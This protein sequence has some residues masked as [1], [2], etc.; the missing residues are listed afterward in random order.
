MKTIYENGVV[1]IQADQTA[2]AFLVEDGR[3][4]K[5]GS[6]REARQWEADRR[7]DLKGR[8]VCPGFND[9]HMHLLNYGQSLSMAPLH[10]HTGSL[11]ALLNCLKTHM[12]EHPVSPGQW[13]T[14]RGWNQDFFTDV[15]RFPNRFDLDQVSTTVPV[16]ISRACGHAIVANS[17]ALELAGITESTP[18]I[19]GGEIVFE[20][21][22]PNGV[23]LDNAASLIFDILPAPNLEQIKDM[24]RLGCRA[25]NTYGVTSCQSDDYCVFSN[26]PWETVNQAFRELEQNGELTVRVYEQCNFTNMT[27]LQTFVEAG[28]HTGVGTDFFRIGPLKM[29]GDGALG[30]R[31]AFLS[32]PYADNPGTRGIPVFSQKEFDEMIGFAHS[33][34]MQTAVHAIGD[35]C[36]DRVIAAMEKAQA[37][38]PRDNTRSGIVHCQITRPDQLD[39]LAKLHAHIY[40]QSI[41]LDYDISIVEN[42]AG[43]ELAN[44]SYSWKTLKKN[45]ATV[46]NG[47]D[48]PVERPFALGGIQCAVTRKPLSGEGVPYLPEQAFT[49]S[50]ALDSYTSAGAYASFEENR[51]G[52]ISPGMLAD[53]VILEENLLCCPPERIKNISISAVFLNG[54]PLWRSDCMEI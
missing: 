8:F 49:V 38:C 37:A 43:K 19:A 27:D 35:A 53:F 34:G 2:E 29:L 44:S 47:T 30:A 16:Y 50:E 5:V 11:R 24:L 13:L 39:K 52:R 42:R 28:N 31:T 18:Q 17:K 32:V 7:I 10:E 25:L 23:L 54:N 45:G 14:G 4:A 6:N 22:Q 41:F 33:H 3:F 21:G 48:C 9:S 46:S 40:A 1:Y 12:L 26:V 15:H 36:L 20:N 51:K